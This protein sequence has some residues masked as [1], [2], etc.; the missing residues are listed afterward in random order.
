MRRAAWLAAVAAVVCLGVA[1]GP[2]TPDGEQPDA[3]GIPPAQCTANA[4]CPPAQQ[5]EAG[6]CTTAAALT[7]A[8]SMLPRAVAGQPYAAAL[9]VTG[10]AGPFRFSISQRA[11][12]LAWLSLE[13]AT[14]RLSGIPPSA[15]TQ[16][17]AVQLLVVDDTRQR[18]ERTFLLGVDACAAGQPV[19]C[20]KPLADGACGVGQGQCVDGKVVCEAT[21]PS[22]SVDTCGAE[23]G[24]C[25]DAGNACNGGK[26]TCGSTGAA[27]GEGELCCGA[28][29]AATCVKADSDAANCGTCGNACPSGSNTQG[30]CV[31]GRCESACRDGFDTCVQTQACGTSLRTTQNCGACGNTCS[32]TQA[33]TC[34]DAG[35]GFYACACGAQLGGCG[36]GMNCCG[37]DALGGV[38]CAD[39][40]SGR[41]VATGGTQQ[42]LD[43][44]ACG[45]ACAAIQGHAAPECAAGACQDKC[46]PGWADCSVP[47]GTS[48]KNCSVEL[49]SD[50]NNCG[51]CG[52][53]CVDP[54]NGVASCQEGQCV[55]ACTSGYGVCTNTGDTCIDFSQ[56]TSCGTCGNKCPAPAVLGAGT[57]DTGCC[58]AWDAATNSCKERCV[59]G[60]GAD[61]CSCKYTC[62]PGFGDCNQA[63]GNLDGCETS[64]ATDKQNCGACGTVC[65]GATRP[66]VACQA[67][68][69]VTV[70]GG[71]VRDCDLQ[72]DN[73]C[74]TDVNT[75]AAHCGAC[76]TV[77]PAP[78]PHTV[79]V[80]TNGS[81][82]YTCE[83]GWVNCDGSPANGCETSETAETCI[84]CGPTG[85]CCA[86]AC[87][88]PV[89]DYDV[90]TRRYTCG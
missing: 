29:A 37:Q 46:E 25:G 79:P 57:K 12:A 82:G 77:C 41:L 30:V 62:Q 70:C 15:L 40:Q 6:T 8:T 18:A 42:V 71:S 35:G 24:A 58:K 87:G 48:P 67:G 52:H 14:G 51:A 31:A 54:A 83:A 19:A 36:P 38:R 39:L 66:D 78:G 7:L 84:S 2:T 43:C 4:D 44:G 64:V 33:D 10:G 86:S 28:G 55:V 9:E 90:A 88:T 45:K 20:A 65:P 63:D 3:G 27:C 80:C 53:K 76:G 85:R 74:E 61:T 69:C 47:Q 26:C 89:C 22:T 23:C 50:K 1:C 56:P 32:P 16:D 75:N 81:C 34:V 73:G 60:T 17:A 49:A 11:P 5:C 72:L 13:A 68:A 21:A 59:A